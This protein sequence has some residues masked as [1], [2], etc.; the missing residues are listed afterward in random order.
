MGRVWKFGDD[1]DTD[2]IIPGKYLV[3]NEAE[4][5]AKHAFENIRRDFAK[6][7]KKGDFIVAGRN[8]GCG[9]SREHAVLALK[10]AG[11]SAVVAKSFARIFFRNA[12]N[13]GLMVVEC[14]ETDKIDDGDEIEIDYKS[15]EIKNLT[16]GEK[17]KI[18]PI[19]EFLLEIASEGLIA[20]CRRM[21]R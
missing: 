5:L 4:E 16:K 8:F 20:Y 10:G 12:I 6:N 3:Y 17:Y 15:G 2:V 9:S 7:V 14:P 11:I 21:L 19:P 18:N 13:T 1:V